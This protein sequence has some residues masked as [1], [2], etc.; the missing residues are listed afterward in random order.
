MLGANVFAIRTQQHTNQDNQRGKRAF[1]FR[2]GDIGV[3][4]YPSCPRY[5]VCLSS[6]RLILRLENTSIAHPREVHFALALPP[7]VGTQREI[8]GIQG[9]KVAK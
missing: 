2:H 6:F 5:L 1:I 7:C 9:I 3:P 4:S 8:V